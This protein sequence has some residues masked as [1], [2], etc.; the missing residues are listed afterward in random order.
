MLS[1]LGQDRLPAEVLVVSSSDHSPANGK[2][3]V[4]IRRLGYGN[5]LIAALTHIDQQYEAAVACPQAPVP[6]S[7]FASSFWDTRFPTPNRI[8]KIQ[9]LLANT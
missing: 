1:P 4:G 5:T 7:S 2:G 8:A 3:D 9:P 6:A